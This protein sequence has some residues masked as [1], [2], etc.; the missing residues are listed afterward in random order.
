MPKAIEKS[1]KAEFEFEQKGGEHVV[2]V[3]EYGKD[4]KPLTLPVDTF[5]A[6]FTVKPT[7]TE[8]K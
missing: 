1:T 8:T 7:T 3:K 5:N 6:M 2:T 4:K